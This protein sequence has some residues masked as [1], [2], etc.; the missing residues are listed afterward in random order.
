M[1]ALANRIQIAHAI[2]FVL[3][4]GRKNGVWHARDNGRSGGLERKS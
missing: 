2:I 1:N 3:E 4:G